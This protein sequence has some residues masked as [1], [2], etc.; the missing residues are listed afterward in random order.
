MGKEGWIEPTVEEK[1]DPDRTILMLS[2]EKRQAI[3]TSDKKTSDISKLIGL[4]EPR[5]RV[6]MNELV[7]EGFVESIGRNKIRR[8]RVNY[9]E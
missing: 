4:S 3:K 5:T 2:F 7:K 9:L 1:Y 8:Y 6:I